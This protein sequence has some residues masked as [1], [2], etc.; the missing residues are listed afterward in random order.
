MPRTG[1]LI[2]D[3]VGLRWILSKFLNLRY[4][5]DINDYNSIYMV[6][7]F[8]WDFVFIHLKSILVDTALTRNLLCMSIGLAN[9]AFRI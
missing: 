5:P 3:L 4:M 8:F 1:A 6:L 7:N 9:F 2:F